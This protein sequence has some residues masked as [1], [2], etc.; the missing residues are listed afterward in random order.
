[1]AFNEIESDKE[2]S[3]KLGMSQQLLSSK[4][5]GNISM[6]TIELMADFF[7]VPMNAMFKN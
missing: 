7:N 4:L 3:E 2:L 5:K 6:K 1:M